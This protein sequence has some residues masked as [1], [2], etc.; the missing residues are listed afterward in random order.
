MNFNGLNDICTTKMF[1][2]KRPND[3]EKWPGS[4]RFRSFECSSYFF[5]G[6]PGVLRYCYNPSVCVEQ[7]H[8]K[9]YI[10]GDFLVTITLTYV[11]LACSVSILINKSIM[12]MW[13]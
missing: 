10:S 5:P 8:N 7:M 9:V 3:R 12:S 4:L 11:R 6:P 2:I 1:E 13:G